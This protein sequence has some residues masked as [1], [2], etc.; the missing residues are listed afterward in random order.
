VTDTARDAHEAQLVA[1]RRL[2][3]D[4]RV[5]LAAEMSEDAR[6]IAAEGERRRKP[7]LSEEEARR[8]VLHRIWG[9]DLASRVEQGAARRR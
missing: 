4:G 6:R 2:G 9:P 1:L 8:I 3:A 7:W 5:R